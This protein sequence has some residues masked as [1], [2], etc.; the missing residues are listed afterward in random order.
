M[1]SPKTP[2]P[3]RRLAPE[4][5]TVLLVVGVAVV[6]VGVLSTSLPILIAGL[7][8]A[9]VAAIGSDG[10]EELDFSFIGAKLSI[11]RRA[12]LPRNTD[13]EDPGAASTQA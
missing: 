12:G 6:G 7:V 1:S 10:L 2:D 4:P 9:V 3:L 8:V 13:A 11:R 5:L